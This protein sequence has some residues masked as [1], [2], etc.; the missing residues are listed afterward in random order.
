MSGFRFSLKNDSKFM[1]LNSKSRPYMISDIATIF[2]IK[3][4]PVFVT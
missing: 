2:L 3:I 1:R 4:V